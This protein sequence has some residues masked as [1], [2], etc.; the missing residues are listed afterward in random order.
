MF[1]NIVTPCS[2]PQNLHKISE[3]INIPQEN[4]RWIIVFDGTVKPNETLIPQNCEFYMHTNP[5]SKV[6]HSQRNFALDLIEKGH[7]YFNDDDTLI[8]PELWENIK[9]LDND[10][11]TFYQELKNGMLRLRGNVMLAH[12]DSHNFIISRDLIAN[13]KWVVNRYDADGVFAIEC[14]K[15]SK[16]HIIIHKVLSTYNVLR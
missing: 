8:H 3:S 1:L 16:N 13:T 10:F 14:H 11:I 4:Y 7:V 5:L 15:K 2:R 6:G 9:D 12:I